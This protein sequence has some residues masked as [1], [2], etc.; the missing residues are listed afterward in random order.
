MVM[1]ESFYSLGTKPF[2]GLRGIDGVTLLRKVNL[3]IH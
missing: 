3:S 2:V 1:L